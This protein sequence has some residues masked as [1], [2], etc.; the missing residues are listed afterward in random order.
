[1]TVAASGL[2]MAILHDL[3]VQRTPPNLRQLS[4]ASS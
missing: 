2:V 3:L 1:V 4:G